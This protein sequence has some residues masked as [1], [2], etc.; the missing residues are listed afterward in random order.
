MLV[1]VLFT[2]RDVFNVVIYKTHF[3]Q[4]FVIKISKFIILVDILLF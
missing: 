2:N 3:L 1:T 4:K